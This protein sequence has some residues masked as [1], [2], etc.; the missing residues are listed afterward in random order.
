MRKNRKKGFTMVELMVVLIILSIIAAVAVPFFINYWRKAEFRKNEENAK[1]VY[2]AAE[3]KLTYYRSSGQWDSFK[4]QIEKKG[5]QYTGSDLNLNGKIYA[6]TLNADSYDSK[7]S[8]KNPVLTLIDDYTYDKDIYKGA[9]AIEI[10]IESGEVYSAFYAT[11][12]D[13]LNYAE[14]DEKH[15]LTMLDREYESRSKR[16]LGYYSADDTVNAVNLG[17]TK[18]RIATISLQNSERLSLNWSSNVGSSL[19]VSYEITFYL[20]GSDKKLFSMVVSPYDLRKNGWSIDQNK[21]DSGQMASV[22]LKD[23]KNKESEGWEFPLTY[24]DNKYSLV[25]DAMMSAKTQATLASDS[26]AYEKTLSTSICR[27][28][29]MTKDLAKAQNIYATVKAT[30]YAGKDSANLIQKEYKDSESVSSNTANTMYADNTSPNDVKIAAYRHLSNIR[31]YEGEK[32]PAFIL[33]NKNMDWTSAGTGVYQLTQQTSGNVSGQKNV[34]KLAW[35]EN[36]KTS[37]IDFPAIAELPAD[38]TLKGKGGSTLLSNLKLGEDSIID[39]TTANELQTAA[40]VQK[41]GRTETKTAGQVSRPEYLGLFCEVKG[42]IEQVTLQ[43]PKLTFGTEKADTRKYSSL[44][45]IGILAGRSEGN[46]SDTAVTGKDTAVNVSLEQT[47]AG[48]SDGFAMAAVG[49][50]IGSMANADG[51]RVAAGQA[52]KLSMSGSMNVKIPDTNSQSTA[53]GIGGIVGYAS[54]P[55]EK[56]GAKIAE[57]ENHANIN[58]NYCTGGIAGKVTGTLEDTNYRDDVLKEMSDLTDCSN[59]GLVLCNISSVA[60]D[61]EEGKYFGGVVGYGENTLLYGAS[62]AAGQTGYVYDQTKKDELLRGEYVGGIIGYGNVS[63]LANCSTKSGGYVLGSKYV[64]GIA[65]GLGGIS[66]A[67]RAHGGVSVTTN[68]NYV[69]GNSYV[70]GIVGENA[71]SVELTDCINNGVTAGYEKYIGGIVG[72]NANGAT[73]SNCASYLSDYDNSIYNTIVN[74]W[75]AKADYAGGI[76]GYNDG[77]ILFSEE[78]QNI[79]VKSVSSIVVGEDYVGGVVGFNDVNARISV[80]YTLI[81]G[82]IY[83]FGKCAGGAFGLNASASVTESDLKIRPRSV[84]GQ[85]FVGGCI[86]ANLINTNNDL[87]MDGIHTDNILGTI[88]GKAFCGGVVGYISTYSTTEGELR[89]NADKLLPE[90]SADNIP[91]YA[92][93]YTNTNMTRITV[94]TTNNLPITASLY[95]GGILGYSEKNSRIVVKECTNSG[96]ISLTSAAFGEAVGTVK[97]GTFAKNEIGSGINL[98]DEA[99]KLEL[100]LAGGIVGVNLKNQIIDNC[101]NKGSLSGFTGIGGVVGLNAGLIYQCTLS[102][103]FGN[104]ALSYVGGIAGLNIGSDTTF[105]DGTRSYTAGTIEK[106]ST[107]SGKTISGN[108]N[109]GGIV[110]WNLTKGVIRE[111]TSYANISAASDN[112][113]GIAGRNS[114]TI[115]V[116]EDENISR[117]IMSSHGTNVGGIIGINEKTGTLSVTGDGGTNGEIVA[118]G[119]GA[120]ITGYENVGG[121]VGNY[122]GQDSLGQSGTQYLVCK[123]SQVRATHGMVGGI[124]GT[125]SGNVTNTINR[126]GKVTADSG[127]A[128]GI[129]AVN[130][131]KISNSKDYGS[132]SSSSGYAGGIAAQNEADGIIENCNVQGTKT[133]KAEIYSLGVMD[134]G[135]IC[136]VNNGTILGSAPKENVVLKGSA[137]IIGGI[138]GLNNGTVGDS[139]ATGSV[140]KITTMPEINVQQTALVVGGAVGMNQGTVVKVVAEGVNF[141][142]F[143]GYKYLGG[144]VGSNGNATILQNGIDGI[145]VI[146]CAYSGEMTEASS[147]AG[148]CYGGI[149]GIN[150]VLLKD[151]KVPYIKMNIQGVY[152]ATSSSTAEQKEAL[153]SHV[154]GIAGKNETDGSI[155][156]C[157]LEDNASSSLS[158][159]AG[160]LGG[161][162]GFNKGAIEMSGSGETSDIILDDIQEDT[163][164]KMNQRARKSGLRE[165][166]NKYVNYSSWSG[167]KKYSD[168]TNITSGKMLMYMNANGNLGGITA[169]N[170]TTGSVNKCVSGNW[171]ILNKSQ[172]LSVGTGGIIGMNESENDSTYLING[173]FVGRELSTGITNRFAGGI[174]GNQ[175]NSTSSDWNIKNCINYGTIYC[176]NTHYSGGIM[177]QWTGTGGTIEKCRNYGNLQT[178]YSAGWIGASSGIVAQL[179]HPYEKDTYNIV[180]C[181]NYG[182]IYRQNGTSGSGAND[183][184]GILGNIT[185]YRTGNISRGQSFTVQILDCVNEAGVQIYSSSMASGIFG[186]LSC[187][188]ADGYAIQTSTQNVVIRI[189]RC[190][191]FGN[192]LNG[193]NFASGIFGDRY[194]ESDKAGASWS[195]NTIVKE[196]YS[197]NLGD[198]NYNKTNYP[199]YSAASDYTKNGRPEMMSAENRKNN[200]YLDGS[201]ESTPWAFTNVRIS[202]SKTGSGKAKNGLDAGGLKSYGRGDNKKFSTYTCDYFFLYDMD[203]EQYFAAYIYAQQT[204]DGASCRLDGRYIKYN[205]NVIGEVLFYLEKGEVPAWDKLYGSYITNPDNVLIE[206]TRTSYRRIE[207]IVSDSGSEKILA[208]AAAKATVADGQI[209]MVVIPKDLEDSLT[210]EKCDP[211]AY[212]VSIADDQ[213]VTEE[214]VMYTEKESFDIPAG[215]SGVLKITVRSKSMYDDIEESEAINA[216]VTQGEGILP[217]PDVKVELIETGTESGQ[218]TYRY[219]LNNL[220]VYNK[221]YPGWQVKISLFG[222]Y[223]SLTLNA[224]NPTGRLYI[225]Y[226]EKW[227]QIN[228]QATGDGY[229]S[230]ILTSVPVYLPNYQPQIKVGTYNSNDRV[231]ATT[232]I[233]GSSLDD[234]KINVTLEGANTNIVET[235]TI[236]RAE[237]I[238]TWKSGTSEKQNVVFAKTDMMSV[239]KGNAVATF[240]NLPDYLR[241]ASNLKIRLWYSQSGLGPVYTYYDVDTENAANIIELADVEEQTDGTEKCEW[242]YSFSTVLK[243]N[244]GYFNDYNYTSGR[245]FTWLAAPVLD[246]KDGSNLEPTYDDENR[247]QYTFSWDKNLAATSDPKY[248]IEMTGIDADGKEVTI[249]TSAYKE[250]GRS[251]TADGDDWNYTQIRLKVTRIGDASKSQIGLSSTAIYNVSQRLEKPGQPSVV[252]VDENELNYNV[253]WAKIS[254]ETYCMGYQIYVREYSN[255]GELGKETAMGDVISKREAKDGSYSK[256]INLE[257]YAGKRIIVYLVAKTSDKNVYVDSAPGVTYELEI[258]SRLAAPV[259]DGW[260]VSWTHDKEKPVDAEDFKNGTAEGLRINIAASKE[261]IPP[262]GSAYLLKAYVYNSK[263]DAEASTVENPGNRMIKIYP[264]TYEDNFVPVQM[265]MENAQDYYHFMNN[266]SIRYAGKW[267]AY[268]TRISSGNS[269]VSSRWVK[270]GTVQLPYAKLTAPEVEADTVEEE[271]KVKVTDTPEVPSHEEQWNAERTVLKWS[272]IDCAEV[273]SINLK[274]KLTETEA[275]QD[276]KLEG[277]LRVIETTE[278]VDGEEQKKV[279]L[280]QYVY[281]KIKEKTETS[282]EEWKWIWENVKEKEDDSQEGLPDE[283]KIHTF[284]PEVYNVTIESN[285]VSDSG[286]YNYYTITLKPVI[287]AEPDGKGG[288][289]YALKLPDLESVKDTNEV[290]VEHGNFIVTETAMFKADVL[291]NVKAEDAGSGNG[292]DAY[293]AS[294]ETEIKWSR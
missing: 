1:T 53:R 174:I 8:K 68:G 102:E 228:A 194:G 91:V 184:A 76:A 123:A 231:K 234:L 225:A 131:A 192:K 81:G 86:G 80:N 93:G 195:E 177:G 5:I 146:S 92:S 167:G 276:N 280:Q 245:L 57:C 238:G 107:M 126:A 261:S 100:H 151:D 236:Y 240:A 260:K 69:I 25:L 258:P 52:T 34:L 289:R 120:R 221:K 116:A 206:D 265:N 121:I 140:T 115:Q 132:V 285:Y 252:N 267:I 291:A 55:T 172:A 161:V 293:V 122:L 32:N 204:V 15:S 41:T 48:E 74:N 144:I 255:S 294:K 95:T 75:E 70:G 210:Q 4:K 66:Q 271:E 98:P 67:I 286:A 42:T 273:Y 27:L 21:S 256:T 17:T 97:L 157:M 82:R 205:N 85:L 262:G 103:H 272:S 94:T 30:S 264:Q 215:M 250:S 214:H 31:Y 200:F 13:S 222:R 109:L 29:S 168:N 159:E 242:K 193:D 79:T 282:E 145:S 274:G 118:V 72:Y 223:E 278:T 130:V 47:G 96:N 104:A 185:T 201:K 287:I 56:N 108:Q 23:G 99:E 248:K 155:D 292:S 28:A 12:C 10:D 50:V 175:N 26:S 237:L 150:Y 106:C 3:S 277:K 33:T 166:G 111:N 197:L 154:G 128:G 46:I 226:D 173:A 196:C 268:Y 44:K 211:F 179:Y 162:T 148:N 171:F 2:L 180:S 38:Y 24:S 188:E 147:E 63:L 143:S 253:S 218:Y 233:S 229:Q 112:V 61:Y 189:E 153:S 232:S 152:S 284:E 176:Y 208:P 135:A 207:G 60:D 169:F 127:Y 22:T 62:S 119:S 141:N 138:T 58:G 89:E 227:Y 266:F 40:A 209:T 263:E 220:D 213:G 142:D 219:S 198:S 246:Q 65:G 19:D 59:D 51:T 178:T 14:K 181:N 275:G 39:D 84:E 288:F 9:I 54:L 247:M 283:E 18:L 137:V 212:V 7:N 186:F 182:S 78:S 71:G 43:N 230:S 165:D 163:L 20:K 125:T 290:S 257:A 90:L 183:S 37:V 101:T 88:K 202:R 113:G 139:Q 73:I 164:D 259:L 217:E 216:E 64:G 279:E 136:A 6:I 170:G 36:S 149:A 77:N 239:S 35:K 156:G 87:V 124:V 45:G 191:N 235:P 129:T 199:V 158:A 243:N 270:V 203:N 105:T 269:S 114:G 110:G 254:D 281:R 160:M 83:A 241:D 11:K 133:T 16:L 251:F 49:G 187:D 244:R 249:D 134:A 117:S 224:K 190:R